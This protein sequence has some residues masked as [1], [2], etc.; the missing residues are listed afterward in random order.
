MVITVF[1]VFRL[2]TDFVCLYTYEFWKTVRSSVILLLPL[3]HWKCMSWFGTGTCYAIGNA[4]P[5]LELVHVVIGNPCP[6]LELVHISQRKSTSWLKTGTYYVIGNSRP[7]LELTHNMPLE[8]TSWLTTG[9]CYVIGNPRP[10][11]ELAH[12]MSLEIP[13]LA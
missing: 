6:G 1:S 5:G 3:C 8:C 13:V 9:T 12:V 11:L 4:C 2:L 7:G 10:C